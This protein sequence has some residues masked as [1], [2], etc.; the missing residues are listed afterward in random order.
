MTNAEATLAKAYAFED[1]QLAAWGGKEILR[2]ELLMDYSEAFAA[3][4]PDVRPVA[5]VR[6]A[7]LSDRFQNETSVREFK[8]ILAAFLYAKVLACDQLRAELFQNVGNALRACM[9]QLRLS[10]DGDYPS[11]AF[12][13]MFVTG[14]TIAGGFQ[15]IV[16]PWEM[17][18]WSDVEDRRP[19]AFVQMGTTKTNMVRMHT[20]TLLRGPVEPNAPGG[21]WLRYRANADL[22]KILV[23]AAA[24][25]AISHVWHEVPEGRGLMF[26]LLKTVNDYH[27]TADQITSSE[28]MAMHAA[29][30]VV[31]SAGKRSVAEFRSRDERRQQQQ[32]RNAQQES[33][34]VVDWTPV[35]KRVAGAI[36]SVFDWIRR[37]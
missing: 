19:R 11:L 17:A 31:M 10:P 30:E 14:R 25:I 36:Q 21:A 24:L 28:A 34:P 23:P 26:S 27:E 9:A 7:V 2:L 22:T 32:T 18:S 12:A 35:E 15:N 33:F 8:I 20:A 5:A 16:W 13:P 37:K 6:W 3:D 1:S 4:S 29:I